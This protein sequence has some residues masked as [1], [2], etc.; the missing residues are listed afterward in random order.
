MIA[1]LSPRLSPSSIR[2]TEN[3]RISSSICAHVQVCQM[4]RS[5]WRIAG[6]DA[7][8]VALRISNFG[9]VSA[10]SAAVCATAVSSRTFRGLGHGPLAASAV[11]V[12][13]ENTADAGSSLRWQQTGL[14][15]LSRLENR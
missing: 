1:I 2:P 4:P 6:R 3:A 9:N 13:Y 8:L 7:N 14:K 10:P 5:L 15:L 12:G 11:F